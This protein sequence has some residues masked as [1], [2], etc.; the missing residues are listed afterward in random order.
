MPLALFLAFDEVKHKPNFGSWLPC[1]GLYSEKPTFPYG[2]KMTTPLNFYR[3]MSRL[4][5]W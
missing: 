2:H 4:A 1:V 3:G 5:N